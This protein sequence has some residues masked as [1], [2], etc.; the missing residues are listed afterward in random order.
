MY[1]VQQEAELVPFWAD[2]KNLKKYKKNGG[3]DLRFTFIHQ[4]V[5]AACAEG[6]IHL[7]EGG[8]WAHP[9]RLQKT[10]QVLLEYLVPSPLTKRCI[11]SV[12]ESEYRFSAK[13][14]SSYV[15]ENT[16][17]TAR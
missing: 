16:L 7:Q 9:H 17:H 2:Y 15:A 13:N 10:K 5:S 12:T 11:S 6:D 3:K 4:T 1:F 14:H 8:N